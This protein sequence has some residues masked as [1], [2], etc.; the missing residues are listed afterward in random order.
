MLFGR[1]AETRDN[2]QTLSREW[3]V[4]LP[5][6]P[7]SSMRTLVEIKYGDFSRMNLVG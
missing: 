2:N 5:E 1:F 6:D 7:A 4:E 3:V